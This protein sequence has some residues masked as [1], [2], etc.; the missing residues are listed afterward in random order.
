MKKVLVLLGAGSSVPLFPTTDDLTQRLVGDRNWLWPTYCHPD[1]LFP[2]KSL[3]PTAPPFFEGIQTFINSF[4][5]H[6]NANFEDLIDFVESVADLQQGLAYPSFS[7]TG[8]FTRKTYPTA[9]VPLGILSGNSLRQVSQDGRLVI[10][11][12]VY[13]CATQVSQCASTASVNLLL[14][15]LSQ[16]ASMHI[17]SL[18]YDNLVDFSGLSL[19]AG[20]KPSNGSTYKEFDPTFELRPLWNGKAITYTP[21]H[22]SIHFGLDTKNRDLEVVWFDKIKDAQKTVSSGLQTRAGT[23]GLQQ[24]YP[25]FVTGRRKAEATQSLPFSSYLRLFRRAAWEADSWLIVGYGGWD[26][27]VNL[28]LSQI[29][30]ARLNSGNPPKMLMCDS[31]TL[32]DLIEL[33]TRLF[34][35]L[36]ASV[37]ASNGGQSYHPIQASISNQP[38]IGWAWNAGLQ[39]MLC[40][41]WQHY[42]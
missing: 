16:T 20:F 22:G 37:L 24:L 18:N 40:T 42:L 29:L 3:N 33:T 14:Q 7:A 27:H 28:H 4:P 34:V 1:S 5:G 32:K 26:L 41:S 30:R 6:P 11:R 25:L 8:W 31:G 10:F 12:E 19:D 38:Q 21:L 39:S 35:P 36:G 2:R 13:R 23:Q 15:R 17:A 9:S